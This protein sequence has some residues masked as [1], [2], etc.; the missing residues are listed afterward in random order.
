MAYSITI[1][2]ENQQLTAQSGEN[3]LALLRAAGFA[4]EAP[5]GGTGKCGKCRVIV[6]GQVALACQTIVDRNMVVTLPQKE[7]GI[8]L[9][10]GIPVDLPTDGKTHLAID[11]GTTTVVAYLIEN[12]KILAAESRKNPQASFGADVVSRVTFALKDTKKQ[13]T[14]LIRNCI[15]KMTHLLLGA[16]KQTQLDTVSIVGNPAMQQLFSGLSV[17]NLAQ[18]PFSPM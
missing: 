6:D 15:E 7:T 10:D 9:T 16:T 1:L 11:I 3:L 14:T 8:I 18:T 5:C 4:P 12:G 13:L 17:E 2:P